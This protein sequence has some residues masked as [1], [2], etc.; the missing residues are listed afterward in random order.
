MRL[1]EVEQKGKIR[2]YITLLMNPK[3]QPLIGLAKL[4]A[5]RWEIE[6]CYP[7]IKSD[8]QEGKHLRNKQPDLVC[9]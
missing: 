9:Q 4:Y 1:I 3:T 7:E 2:R 8:L 6:M 5:Q